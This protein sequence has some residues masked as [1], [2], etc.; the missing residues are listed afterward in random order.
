MIGLKL[1]SINTDYYLKAARELYAL[2]IFDYIELYYVPNS[3]STLSHWQ[4]LA[5]PFTIHAPHFAHGINLADVNKAEFNYSVYQEVST[6]AETLKAKYVIIHSG[7]EG[8]PDECIRQIKNL[9]IKNFIIENK[10]YLAPIGEHFHCRGASYEEVKYI[11]DN[12]GCGF[13][14]DIGHATSHF[15]SPRSVVTFCSESRP[16]KKAI[17]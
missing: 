13:C 9:G 5:I 3:L 10:P 15:S 8:T 7:M 1:W 4:E 14:F 11:V 2:G 12:L 6:L 17:S 16:P